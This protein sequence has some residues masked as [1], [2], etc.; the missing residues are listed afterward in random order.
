MNI[1]YR[2]K[3]ILILPKVYEPAEDSFLM[4]EAVLREVQKSDRVLE[5]GTGSGIIS[6]FVK[7]IAQVIATDIGPQAVKCAKLNGIDVIRT[8][9]FDGINFRAKFDLIVFNP[10][11]LPSEEQK[12]D[13]DVLWDGGGSG[14]TTINRFLD[15]VKDYLAEDGR[16]LLLAS[17]LTGIEQITAR[18]ESLGLVVD[19]IM[20]E[21]HFFERLVVLRGFL[22]R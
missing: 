2:D 17:S 18:M 14:R 22:R 19:E 20:S 15:R 10:P 16:I 4:V 9:L 21:K 12:T 11:Y 13:M 1:L 5:I 8:D 3:E 6:M 7:D